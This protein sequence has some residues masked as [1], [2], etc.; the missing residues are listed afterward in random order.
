[1]CFVCS[2]VVGTNRSGAGDVREA[3]E[4]NM[5]LERH[6]PARAGCWGATGRRRRGAG[7][8]RRRRGATREGDSRRGGAAAGSR[9]RGRRGVEDASRRGVRGGGIFLARREEAPFG[10]LADRG[11]APGVPRFRRA[12]PAA[13]ARGFR[14]HLAGQ[15]HELRGAAAPVVRPDL[16]LDRD[17]A[18]RAEAR[19]AAAPAGCRALT[20]PRPPHLFNMPGARAGAPLV[21]ARRAKRHRAD[22]AAT[23]CRRHRARRRPRRAL[24]RRAEWRGGA[25]ARVPLENEVFFN[26]GYG[27]ESWLRT[28]ARRRV[29]S[30]PSLMKLSSAFDRGRFLAI[31]RPALFTPRRGAPRRTQA[32]ASRHVRRAQGPPPARDAAS[33]PIPPRSLPVAISRL[34]SI[35][36]SSSSRRIWKKTRATRSRRVLARAPRV[37]EPPPR[38]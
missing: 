38:I 5:S 22:R 21:R 3:R 23:A 15:T 26:S 32:T 36:R 16:R 14:T 20:Q 25:R 35:A 6:R 12:G 17:A 8:G 4:T 2:E 11:S 33:P 27:I 34:P 19:A 9:R 10:G 7:A 29:S 37:L 31:A 18:A 30:V 1:M 24:E 28:T 13:R